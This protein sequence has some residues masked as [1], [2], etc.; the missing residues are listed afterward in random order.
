MFVVV[1]GLLIVGCSKPEQTTN[2]DATTPANSSAAPSPSAATTTA[3]T[4]DM[5]VPECDAFL[6][7]Y[8]ACVQDKVPAAV[9][10]TFEATLAGWKRSWPEQAATPQGKAVLVATC[11]NAHEQ[12]KTSMKAYNCSW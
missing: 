8:Q 7:A 10:P 4:G 9:R 1:A 2:R 11:K 6:K 3:S 5:G 12:A